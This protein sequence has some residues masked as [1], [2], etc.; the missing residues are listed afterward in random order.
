MSSSGSTPKTVKTDDGD[1]ALEIPRDRSSTFEPRFV[2]KGIRR[3]KGFDEKVLGLYARGVSVREIRGFLEDHYQVSISPDLISD[4]TD[5][6][7]DEI[8]TWQQRPLEPIYPV[9]IWMP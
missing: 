9:V 7:L 3:L 1:L 8:T 6:V 5:E 4:V 2:P